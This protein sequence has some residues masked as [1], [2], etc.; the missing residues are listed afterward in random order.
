[1]KSRFQWTCVFVAMIGIAQTAAQA[2]PTTGFTLLPVNF[3]MQK[4]YNIP[5]AQ[6]Y[7]FDSRTNTHHCWVYNTDQPFSEGNTT[8]PRTEMR[9]NPDYTT[10]TTQMQYEADIMVPAGTD[11]VSIFQIHVGDAQSGTY[12]STSF[13]LFAYN[14]A[15]R[16]YDSTVIMNNPFGKWFHLNVIHN[17]STH[18]VMVYI[19]NVLKNT[20]AEGSLGASDWYFKCGVYGQSGQTALTQAYYRNVHLWSEN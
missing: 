9:F 18:E 7:S 17:T 8:D 16:Y 3:Q 14:G 19:N 20:F 11:N 13:M 12:G 10:A 1:M 6:R 15:L 5:L 2:D 4:P